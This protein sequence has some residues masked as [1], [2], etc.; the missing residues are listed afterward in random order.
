M[1]KYNKNL[2][3]VM[4]AIIVFLLLSV[5]YMYPALEGKTVSQHDISMHIGQSKELVD[6]RNETGKNALWT[7]QTFCGMPGYMI[8]TTYPSNLLRKIHSGLMLFGWRPVSF[9]FLYLLGFYLA[10]LAFNVDR[11]LSIVGAIA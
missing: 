4:V 2:F 8:S 11:W 6:F 3:P 5:A 10:L 7:N 1:K 9:V